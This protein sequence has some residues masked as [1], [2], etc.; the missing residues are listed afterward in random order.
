MKNFKQFRTF[1]ESLKTVHP[2]FKAAIRSYEIVFE[3]IKGAMT[4]VSGA[5]P[6]DY[7]V[8]KAIH[9]ATGKKMT[10]INWSDF[11]DPMVQAGVELMNLVN[12]KGYE[13]YVVGG[14]V[15]D[16]AM[17][18]KD[19]HD[20]DIATNMPIDEIKKNF[21]TV[22]Y[23]GGE[24]H[25]TV[26]VH[27]K[28]NDYELTQFRTEGSYSDSRRPDSVEFVQSFEEDTKRRDFTINA[29][30][31]DAEGNVIDYHGGTDDIEK[32][33]LRTVGDAKERFSEDALRILR[34]VRF[35]ARFDFNVDDKTMEAM[36]ELKETVNS[37]S[38]ERI[39][40]ELF[41]TIDYGGDKFANALDLLMETGIWDVIVPEVQLSAEKI[42]QVRQ[43]NTK[44]PK[45]N[46]AILL[47]DKDTNQIKNLG[48]R[49]TLTNDEVKS[50]TFIDAMLEHYAN[51]GGIPRSAA[52]K[53]VVNPDFSIL[54]ETFVAING[55]DIEKSDDIIEKIST[56]KTVTDRQKQ[57]NQFIM[58]AGVQGA[59]FGEIGSTVMNWLFSEYNT[60]NEPSDDEVKGY[61]GK[62]V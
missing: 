51:L 36:K 48:K 56:F 44:D 5:V 28:S 35:A 23:G 29:M 12:Q 39:R 41:K 38:I 10:K 21:K 13:A 15:R 57:V 14:A 27:F 45:I 52:L 4:M 1:L 2:V 3:G 54:R 59:K 20:I 6:S 34:A 18:D 7:A 32:G 30:G 17:G 62:L 49:M 8:T 58:D 60:G 26:I 16:I 33:L 11:E 19:V 9:E 50:I 40:D 24:R 55:R 61:I 22:E 43:A 46:F 37:T 25:G 42:A 47:Q 53:I 31:I